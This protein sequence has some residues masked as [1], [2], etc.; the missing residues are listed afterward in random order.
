MIL[1]LFLLETSHD[2]V[3]D[4]NWN[5]FTIMQ[6]EPK[7][8]LQKPCLF[9]KNLNRYN[10]YA[11]ARITPEDNP[12]LSWVYNFGLGQ[13]FILRY[14]CRFW[15]DRTWGQKKAWRDSSALARSPSSA[16]QLRQ[17]WRSY[18]IYMYMLI[19]GDTDQFFRNSNR[20]ERSHVF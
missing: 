2:F 8:P 9:V 1:C 5:N 20:R 12:L 17:F 3:D 13:M 10:C 15:P 19:S 18:G 11:F 7:W 14:N 4:Q 6:F 16:N